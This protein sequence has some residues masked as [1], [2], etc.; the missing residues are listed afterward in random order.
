MPFMPAFIEGS[1][2]LFIG[3]GT[4]IAFV[5]FL[6]AERPCHPGSRRTVPR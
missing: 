6:A 4:D 3:Q 2:T 5:D 1:Q